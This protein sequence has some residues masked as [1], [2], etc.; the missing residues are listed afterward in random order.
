MAWVLNH[1]KSWADAP[2][3]LRTS[4]IILLSLAVLILFSGIYFTTGT[5]QTDYATASQYTLAKTVSD[6]VGTYTRSCEILATSPNIRA[7]S[8]LGKSD[9]TRAFS[10]AGTVM[11]DVW[12]VNSALPDTSTVSVIFPKTQI[13][14][15]KNQFRI[16]K[17]L[18]DF[19]SA[20][21]PGLSD[22][23]VLSQD[24]SSWRSYCVDGMCYIVRSLHTDGQDA[25][26]L[27]SFPVSE[28]VSGG[29]QDI[30]VIGDT[31]TCMYASRN[32]L[33]DDFY[34]D[35][36]SALTRNRKISISGIRYYITCNVFSN[37]SIRFFTLV[38]LLTETLLAVRIISCILFATLL[39]ATE[40]M[41]F[42]HHKRSAEAKQATAQETQKLDA[43]LQYTL[44]GLAKTLSDLP[45][46]RG[47]RISQ[48]CYKLLNLPMS[49]DCVV[50]G[51]TLIQ[52]QEHLLD[53]KLS[54]QDSLRPITPYFIVNNMLQDL[55]YDR[56]IGGLCYCS[57]KLIALSNLLPGETEADLQGISQQIQTAAMEYLSL[58]F[59]VSEP[60]V[61]HG[62]AYFHETLLQVSRQLDHARLWWNS[63]HGS[64]GAPPSLDSAGFYKKLG[65]LNDCIQEKNYVKAEKVFHQI[66]QSCIPKDVEQVKEAEGRLAI[67]LDTLLSLTGYPRSL[68]S[69]DALP[70]KTIASCQEVAAEIFR[71]QLY[72]QTASGSTPSQERIWAITEYVAQHYSDPELGVGSI[73]NQM[74]MNAA[75]LSRT[76]KMGTGTN[77]LEYIHKT[78]ISAAKKLLP[79]YSI[80]EVSAMVGFVDVQ[81]FSRAFRKFESVTPAEY[82]RNCSPPS[83][84]L[85]E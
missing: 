52:D 5:R 55:L 80:K 45:R 72:A 27:V 76:F 12:N 40:L 67:L 32:G 59:V 28:V 11:Q 3:W 81:S 48:Q 58:A 38:P 23:Q 69:E 75:Y 68:L 19:F 56:H 29:K 15:T 30:T 44:S 21:F 41:L 51:F 47:E 24:D 84:P 16:H 2:R 20:S 74:G 31:E 42:I 6:V 33:S 70:P 10:L 22:E 50:M 14:V 37:L 36:L 54:Q 17:S 35:L 65:L 83:S 62:Y 60:V 39:A 77:L 61:S 63:E 71:V 79:Q 85:P 64:Q 78:R 73:A 18:S 25:H 49:E 57:D 46:G 9:S 7:L 8:E 82:K 53:H 34:E 4:G 13:A 66:L 1:W 26:I 43:G